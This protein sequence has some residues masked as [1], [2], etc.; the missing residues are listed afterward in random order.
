[1]KPPLKMNA[2]Y[3]YVQG[4]LLKPRCLGGVLHNLFLNVNDNGDNQE[5]R[6]N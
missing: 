3:G 1:M 4:F 6:R 5:K 2:R